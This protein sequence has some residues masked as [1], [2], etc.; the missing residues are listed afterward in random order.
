VLA[1]LCVSA[2]GLV[3]LVAATATPA[4]A[5]TTLTNPI[6]L[7]G[8]SVLASIPFDRTSALGVHVTGSLDSTVDWTQAATVSTDFDPNLLRQ[9]RSLDPSDTYT[10]VGAGNMTATWAIDNLVVSW[11]GL[12]PF[13]IGTIGVSANGSCTMTT[14]GGDHLCHLESNRIMVLPPLPWPLGGPFVALKVVADVTVT[15]DGV[16]T[17]RTAT[18]GGNADGTNALDLGQSPVTDAFPI[19]CTVGAGDNLDYGLGT[20]ASH[21]GVS[22]QSGIVVDVGVA[23][24]N[25]LFP[26][27]DPNPDDALLYPSFE[28]PTFDIG[29]PIVGSID[30]M[31]DPT[32]FSMGPVQANNIP[33]TVD[34]GG[35]Y[36]GI[37]GSPIHFDGTGTT[38]V[39]GFDSLTLRWD[40]D[41][42]GVA[43]GGQPYHTFGDNGIHSGLLTVTDPT[44]LSATQAF[45]VDVANVAPSVN[46]GPDTTA[47]WGRPVAFNGQATDPGWLDQPTLQYTWSFGDG[48]PSASGGPSVVHS[49]ALPS[50]AGYTA[51]LTVCDKDLACTSDSRTVIV[52]KRD[53]TTSYLGDT[54]GTY[55]TPASVSASLVDEYGQAVNGRSVAFQVGTDPVLNGLTNSS[56]IATKSY[57]PGLAAGGYTAS[58]AFAGD[59]LYNPSGSSNGFAI[60]KK[61]T[62]ITYTGAVTGAPNKT[63]VLSA[64]LKDATGKALAG[65]TVDFALGSQSASAVTDVNGV[66]STSLKLAQ[67]NGTYTVS[68]TYSTSG[69]NAADGPF[70]TGSTQGVVFKLQAK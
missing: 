48:S 39:C 70:Y 42:G 6:N 45:S 53:T 15:P 36:S 4:A 65:R 62:S 11:D 32:S 61:A 59:V 8:H 54:S 47:D 64:V 46:A 25:P 19:P 2:A 52:T 63:I 21:Q 44:G 43:F 68:A 16:A 5:N 66:A 57:V 30:M 67:K 34:A 13:N 69:A 56:G 28:T 40:F 51:T 23:I 17:L 14:T 38:S 33:P 37:E 3:G 10:P 41:D 20:F 29:P 1:A 24:P 22:V 31:G 7:T 12:G 9:G 35:P 60:A 49:Y 55:D 58:A 18:F 50:V 26:F 27:P